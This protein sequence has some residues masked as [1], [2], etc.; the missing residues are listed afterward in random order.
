MDATSIQV[1]K[2]AAPKVE[3]ASANPSLADLGKKRS[4]SRVTYGGER[5]KRVLGSQ[6]YMTVEDFERK[7]YLPYGLK[8]SDIKLGATTEKAV[9]A[10][11]DAMAKRIAELEAQ[12]AAKKEPVKEKDITI[13]QDYF[14]D[15]EVEKALPKTRRKRGGNA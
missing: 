6:G 15:P 11:V 3:R 10:E 2:V 4:M 8:A 5:G 14:L 13:E 7:N 9:E 12:L 1:I